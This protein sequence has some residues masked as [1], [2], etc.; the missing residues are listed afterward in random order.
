MS[1][2]SRNLPISVALFKQYGPTILDLN[3]YNYCTGLTF[4]LT[5]SQVTKKLLVI[6]CNSRDRTWFTQKIWFYINSRYHPFPIGLSKKCQQSLL[7]LWVFSCFTSSV[8][9]ANFF[10]S[11]QNVCGGSNINHSFGIDSFLTL[12]FQFNLTLSS[13][14]PRPSEKIS[15]NGFVSDLFQLLYLFNCFANLFGRNKA[16]SRK[17]NK[18]P[19]IGPDPFPSLWTQFHLASI[20]AF[21]WFVQNTLAIFLVHKIFKFLN[22]FH[23]FDS[24]SGSNE[25]SSCKTFVF[26]WTGLDS[27]LGRWIYIRFA[28]SSAPSWFVAEF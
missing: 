2:L 13:N 1:A 9:F 5:W 28:L 20:S 17:S 24:F 25:T 23:C 21:V 12:R 7:P 8:A 16:F 4:L 10:A 6:I 3:F 19:C 11:N 26:P 14:F 18:I 22:N 27:F 15:T